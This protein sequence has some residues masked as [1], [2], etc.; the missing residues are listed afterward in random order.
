VDNRRLLIVAV[1]SLVIAGSAHADDDSCG[2]DQFHGH[3]EAHAR[4]RYGDLDKLSD[5]SRH[6]AEQIIVLCARVDYIY[7]RRDQWRAHPFKAQIGMTTDQ[8]EHG[9]VW[10]PPDHINRTETVA[11]IREQWVYGRPSPGFLYFEAGRLV[12]IQEEGQ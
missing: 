3:H 12:S 10:G 11:G 4:Q 7:R 5:A 9:T 2:C 6:L 8:V 1:A